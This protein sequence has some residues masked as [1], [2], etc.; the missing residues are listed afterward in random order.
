[1]HKWRMTAE[2]MQYPKGLEDDR[3]TNYLTTIGRSA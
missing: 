3:G 1:M 2:K